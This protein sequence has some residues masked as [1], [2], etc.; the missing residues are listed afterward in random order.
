MNF[1]SNLAKF[2]DNC[3]TI[4]FNRKKKKKKKKNG[5]IKIVQ[6]LLKGESVNIFMI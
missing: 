4:N 3:I 2:R 1:D 6:N 5:T